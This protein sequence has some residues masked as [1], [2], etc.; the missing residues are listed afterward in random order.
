MDQNT[1]ALYLRRSPESER[2]MT[3]PTPADLIRAAEI[4]EALAEWFSKYPRGF[5]YSRQHEC[6]ARAAALRAV[7]SQ[8]QETE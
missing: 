3:R 6:E 2:P 8:T 7:A 1:A 4:E 5:D